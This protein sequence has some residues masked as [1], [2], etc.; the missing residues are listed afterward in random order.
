MI[1]PPKGIIYTEGQC[2]STH[3]QLL[4]AHETSPQHLTGA[5]GSSPHLCCAWIQIE[6]IQTT[7]AAPCLHPCPPCSLE[8]YSKSMTLFGLLRSVQ[9]GLFFRISI[10]WEFLFCPRPCSSKMMGVKWASSI[11]RTF[12]L[13]LVLPL[14]TRL[15][16]SGS[17]DF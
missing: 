11:L 3:G 16:H 13:C 12:S 7:A 8:C 1:L 6:A 17:L 5:S 4:T 9:C 15:V 10:S 14:V 2:P